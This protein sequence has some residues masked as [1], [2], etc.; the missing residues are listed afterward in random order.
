M[1]LA[2][3]PNNYLYGKGRLYFKPT[4]GDY[5]DLGNVPKFAIAVEVEKAEH[6]SS[7]SGTRDKD[8]SIVL[9]KSAKASLNLEECNADNLDI[10][11]MGDGVVEGS[12]VAGSLDAVETTTVEDRFVDLG[13]TD[14][15]ILKISHGS[16][17]GGP[18]EAGET[19]TGGTSSATATVAWEDDSDLFLEVIDVS[20]GPFQIGETITGGTSSASAAVSGLETMEDAVVTDA[21]TPTVRYEAGTDYTVDAVAGLLRE[22]SGGS[23]ASNTCYVSADYAATSTKSVRAFKNAESR[24]ELLFIGDPDQGPKLRVQ[25]WDVNLTISGEGEFISEDILSIP[26]EAEIFKA[27][28]AHPSEPFFRVTEIS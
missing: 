15:S 21:A 28:T 10:A 7:R 26:M 8:L 27:E 16:V 5:L 20:G 2:H 4:G 25:V 11:F 24:G 22:L 6:F 17:S 12:Q 19:I 13:K 23:I 3:D 1:P 14:L 9:E 18:F